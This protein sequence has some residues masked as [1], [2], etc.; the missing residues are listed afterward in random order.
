MEDENAGLSP[1]LVRGAFTGREEFRACLRLALAEAA[2]AG[3]REMIALDPDFADWPLGEPAVLATLT[4]WARV[5]R[6]KLTVLASRYD[7]VER[8]HPLFV[9]WR[10][11]WSH[12]IE[13]RAVSPAIQSDLPSLLWSPAWALQRHELRLSSG[14][15]LDDPERRQLLR[16]LADGWLERSQPAFPAY[17][18]GL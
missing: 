17:T 18:L 13:C 9:E 15:C 7:Q 11:N 16:Q 12:R 1:Q 8:L 2:R 3:W 14:L 5:G 6:R 10:R 4:T